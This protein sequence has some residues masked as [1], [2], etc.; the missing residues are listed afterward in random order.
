MRP[1]NNSAGMTN[2]GWGKIL[3]YVATAIAALIALGAVA[4]VAFNYEK[5]GQPVVPLLAFGVAGIIWLIGW[6]F[7]R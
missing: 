7:R 1:D 3:Y 6:F 4:T 5:E 2:V